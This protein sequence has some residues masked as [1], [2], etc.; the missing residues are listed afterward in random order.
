MEVVTFLPWAGHADAWLVLVIVVACL[1]GPA[2]RT[3]HVPVCFSAKASLNM[4]VGLESLG[5]LLAAA[6]PHT[7]FAAGSWGAC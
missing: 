7:E 5:H 2:A 3:G 4:G 6:L 1:G